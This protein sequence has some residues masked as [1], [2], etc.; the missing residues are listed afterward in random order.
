M[1]I[2]LFIF[3]LII[4][5]P[6]LVIVMLWTLFS[7]LFS[8]I[9]ERV[10]QPSAQEAKQWFKNGHGYFANFSENEKRRI[11]GKQND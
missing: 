7:F 11:M 6:F 5:V 2:S 10:T 4:S 1:P 3:L 8:L 9:F